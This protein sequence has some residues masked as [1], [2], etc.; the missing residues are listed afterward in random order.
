MASF[1]PDAPVDLAYRLMFDSPVTL[2][3]RR[4]ILDEHVAWLAEH[5]YQVLSFDASTWATKAEMLRDIA[6]ALEFPP[7]SRH[8]LDGFNDRMRDV[9]GQEYGWRP[10]TT[11]LALVFTRYDAIAAREPDA[12]H[13]VLDILTDQS[14]SAMLLGRRLMCLVQSDDP[15]IHFGPLGAVA[16]RWNDAET[17]R[18]GPAL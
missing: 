12:A 7:S 8:S 10:D 4:A 16:A 11:G 18:R 14:R 17:L 9:V 13:A 3:W 2:Y 6:I 5:G 1:D 15:G